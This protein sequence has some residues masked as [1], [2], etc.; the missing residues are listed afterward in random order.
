MRDELKHCKRIV[1]KVGTSILAAGDGKISRKNFDRLGEPILELRKQGAEV[2][3]VS[4]GAIAFG[5]QAVQLK[6][7]PS[8]IAKLQACAAIGQGKLMHAYEEYFGR[9]GHQTAQIL[10]TR[11]GLEERARFLA[12]RRTFFELFRMGVLPIVNE[13]DTVSTEEI[14]FGDN[15]ILSVHVAHLIEADLLIILSDVDGFYLKDGSRL[16]EVHSEKDIENNLMKHLSDK[17]KEQTVGGMKAKLC[18]ARVA[19]RLG[20]PLLLVSG[21]EDGVIAKALRAEDCGTLFLASHSETDARKKWIAFSARR[22]GTVVIDDG[23]YEALRQKKVSLLPSGITKVRGDFECAE[24]V[25]LETRNGSVIGRGVVRYDAKALQKI[26]GKKTYE[27]EA[28]L[29]YKH[30]D[31]VIH[32]N[33]LVL[34]S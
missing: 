7:R 21:R 26:A 18:A 32:R 33:D 24:V 3:L 16:R 34:W 13:N 14:A 20:V 15:D 12:A 8:E 2:V 27:I 17:R 25:E 4:S 22:K 23:A 6:K 10:L 28:V 11:D 9:Q 5:M 19:M 1:I 31:E 29:G 30:H